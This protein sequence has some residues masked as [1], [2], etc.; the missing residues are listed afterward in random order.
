[1]VTRTA[2]SLHSPSDTQTLFPLQDTSFLVLHGNQ[3]ITFKKSWFLNES[4][5]TTEHDGAN[6]W[7]TLDSYRQRFHLNYDEG[8]TVSQARDTTVSRQFHQWPFII[9]PL[10]TLKK[11]SSLSFKCS[12]K[13][14]CFLASSISPWIAEM[15]D[16]GRKEEKLLVIHV[17]SLAQPLPHSPGKWQGLRQCQHPV[18]L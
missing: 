14:S 12:G 8:E 7:R 3:H 5:S 1:M 11:L 16:S 2:A 4:F 15:S 17:T 13:S 18:F 9:L 10:E 6:S